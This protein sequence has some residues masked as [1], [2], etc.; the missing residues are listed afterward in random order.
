[1]RKWILLVIPTVILLALIVG[2]G[3]ARSWAERR[4][5]ERAAAYYPPGAG[6]SA[7]IHSFPFIGRL[8]FLGSVPRVDVNLDDLRFEAVLIRRLS[9]RVS[10]VKLDRDELFGGRVRIEDVGEG[11]IV[12]TVDGPSLARATGFD[13]RFRPG[14]VEVHRRIQGVD[15]VAKGQ[16][17]VQG[18]LVT[19]TP[20]S[21][22]GLAVPASRFAISYRIPGIELLPCQAD[23]QIIRDAV[24]LSCDVTDVPAA[25]VQAAQS[26]Q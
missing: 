25:L 19:V 14:E 13:V 22:Q 11:R 26:G 17:A 15:V 20:T 6:S 2:D 10:D 4:L 21:V 16:L 1:V 8:L 12:A 18:N 7:R 24:T 23:V 9:L 3:A 5:A